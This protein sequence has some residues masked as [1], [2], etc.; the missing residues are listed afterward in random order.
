MSKLSKRLKVVSSEKLGRSGVTSQLR[1]LYEGVVMGI[2]M[3]L[4]EAKSKI[5]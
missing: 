5:K 2:H 4:V 3:S 1:Y